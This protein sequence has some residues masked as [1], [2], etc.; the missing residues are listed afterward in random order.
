M[1]PKRSTKTL[2]GFI[3]VLALGWAFV[4]WGLPYL[5]KERMA[6]APQ[7]V[8]ED[9]DTGTSFV[10]S[11]MERGSVHTYRG[12]LTLPTPCH[13]FSSGVSLVD[14]SSPQARITLTTIPPEAGV[15]CAQVLTPQEFVVS[16][17][18]ALR[19]EVMLSVDG[20]AQEVSVVE[21]I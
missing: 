10:L 21:G 12:E 4:S 3:I 11:H 18:S 15:L 20:Q 7:N 1:D 17:E 16:V 13:G 14:G 19:P 6:N 2:V 5:E 8:I 9:T